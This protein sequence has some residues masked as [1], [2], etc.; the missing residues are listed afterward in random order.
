[1]HDTIQT[2]PILTPKNCLQFLGPSPWIEASVRE[3]ASFS[4]IAAFV[5]RHYMVEEMEDAVN[6][7]F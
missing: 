3:I 2:Q 6:F 7:F 1:M 5:R 4:A